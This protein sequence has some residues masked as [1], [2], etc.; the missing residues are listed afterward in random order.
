MMQQLTIRARLLI[1]VGAMLTAC[2]VIG[3]TGLNA[4]QRSVAGLNTV[5]LDR[6][7]PL[8]DL[9][10]IADL[11]AVK[12]VDTTHKTRS[13]MLSYQQ[14]RD[15]VRTARAEIRRIWGD[16]MNTDLIA[17]ERQVS[18]RIEALMQKA[19]TPLDDLER[20]LDRHSEKRLAAFVVNDLYPLIDP[21]SEG[22]SELIH[23]QLG[24]AKAEY[25]EALALYERN[26]VLN[27]GLLLALLIGG[28][29]FSMVLL[30]SISRPRVI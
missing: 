20:I 23:L 18:A 30:R 10:L 22:F 5:Y 15:D 27:I 19:E 6:V 13:G 12:I 1:L 28:G 24:E 17:A 29:L 11:Y 25:D 3:L 8:R 4:Q 26:R 9:K 2:L 16:Y 14:A 21:I 7:V